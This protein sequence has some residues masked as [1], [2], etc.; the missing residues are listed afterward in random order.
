MH[1]IYKRFYTQRLFSIKEAS[2]II[3]NHQVCKN[4]LGRLKTKG[5]IKRLKKGIY[6]IIPIDNKDF[7]PNKNHIAAYQRTDYAIA[8]NSALTA[9]KLRPEQNEPIWILSKNAAKIQIKNQTIRITK[10]RHNFGITSIKYNT[11]YNEIDL[12]ITDIERTI[13][14]SILTRSI[15]LEELIQ[16]SKNSKLD[17]NRII[18]YIDKYKK[19]ILYNKTGVVLEAVKDYLR[20]SSDDLERLRK[21]LG[22]KIYY[23]KER[24]LTLMRPK[25]KYYLKWNIMLPEPLY[26]IVQPK[27]E[28][29][30]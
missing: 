2:K 10:N 14:D 30:Q 6:Y 25:Y 3:K 26:N 11:G 27:N 9:H 8:G 12:H 7:Y 21:K 19:P 18:G 15:K 24:G 17:I 28:T 22:K 20:I 16:I 1:T 13:L 4:T 5:Y 29:K 23:A